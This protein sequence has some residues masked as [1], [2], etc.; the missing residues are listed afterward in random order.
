METRDCRALRVFDFGRITS[1]RAHIAGKRFRQGRHLNGPSRIQIRIL[2]RQT[3]GDRRHFRTRLH[4]RNALFQ[5][6]K[7]AQKIVP[8]SPPRIGQTDRS[9]IGLMRKP[10]LGRREAIE[11]RLLK[12]PRHDADYRQDASGSET[13][14]LAESKLAAD[15]IRIAPEA[16]TPRGIT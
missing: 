2:L 7:C 16:A 14:H 8:A 12:I 3:S 5:S 15:D 10:E 11:I 1:S 13:G 6:R 4:Q 9:Q